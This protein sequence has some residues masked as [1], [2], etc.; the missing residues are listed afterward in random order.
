ML[1]IKRIS[2][3]NYLITIII[4]LSKHCANNDVIFFETLTHA[5]FQGFNPAAAGKIKR[6][7]SK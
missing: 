6:Y 1:N 4:S 3:N 5:V 2:P 7:F